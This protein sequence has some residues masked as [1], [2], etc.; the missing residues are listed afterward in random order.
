MT[1]DVRRWHAHPHPALCNSG[2]TVIAHTARVEANCESLCAAL[3]ISYSENL[4]Y[5][6]RN[7]DLPF[8]RI[9]GDLPA[10]LMRRYRVARLAKRI[11][12]W[13]IARELGMRWRLTRQ[14]AL[15]LGLCDTLDAALW[16]RQVLTEAG[17]FTY[18]QEHFAADVDI[19]ADKAA[20]L[21]RAA[22]VWLGKTLAK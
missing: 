13:Q 21:G 11:L 7:H 1:H 3:G 10:T 12:E 16:A 4:Q 8:E 17:D 6:A 20:K 22:V 18:W 19:C 14:E 9:M 2:D 5:A 15:I